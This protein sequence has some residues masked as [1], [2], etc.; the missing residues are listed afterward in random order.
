MTEIG[1]KLLK[2]GIYQYQNHKFEAALES[3]QEALA[4]YQEISDRR[5]QAAALGNIGVAYNTLLDYHLAIEYS[6]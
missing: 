4:I 3:W 6:P 1:D 5:K 2:Q